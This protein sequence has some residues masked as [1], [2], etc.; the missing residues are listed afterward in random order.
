MLDSV[1]DPPHAPPV[2]TGTIDRNEE[3]AAA[4]APRWHTRLDPRR[5]LAAAIGWAI[6]GVIVVASLVAANLAATAAER[7]GRADTQRLLEQFAAQLHHALMTNIETRLTI[8]RATAA[9]IA[10]SGDRGKAAL[11][12]H[13]EAV[14]A[15][16]PE[17]AWIGVTDADGRVVAATQGV[18]EA[19]SVADRPWFQTARAGPFVGE[20]RLH[21]RLETLLAR[22]ADAGPQ[23]YV[24]AAA[25]I[26]DARGP[27]AG[28]IGGYLAWS[29]VERLQR[30]LLG[31][32][33]SGVPL[34]LV[35]LGGDGR[36]IGGP[37]GWVGR[38]FA[39]L[40]ASAGGRYLVARHDP[41]LR[42]DG[43]ALPW[44]VVVRQPVALALAPAQRAAQ[45]VFLAVL[46]AGLLAALAA[47]LLTQVLTRRLGVLAG[48]I[49]SVRRGERSA[50]VV[51]AGRD[52]VG[53]I[54]IVLAALVD[55]LQREKGA[56]AQLNR[57]LDQRVAE[58][59]ARIERLAEEGRAAA[60][61]RERLRLA[62]ELHDTLAHSLMALLAQI[63]L[64]RKL[65]RRLGEDELDA[66]LDRAEEVAARGLTE[67]RA[68][69]TQMRDGG[70]QEV[71]LGA[72]L[73]ELLARFTQ[74]SG[75]AAELHADV[76]AAAMS[77]ERAQTLYRIAEEALRNVE[78]HAGA[79]RVTVELRE[80]GEPIAPR[81]LLR[82]AD[83]GAGFDPAAPVP[84]HYGLR[85]MREQAALIEAA[86]S[87]HSAPGAG[88]RIELEFAA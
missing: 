3:T 39:Q 18:F 83:D 78:R 9:Q 23:R 31:A 21:R 64:V 60:V 7:R 35:M 88:T 85:G 8:M 34:E 4:R 27:A 55:Q 37:A 57:E 1:A 12:R 68:A 40:D 67:A 80:S 73:R 79:R 76:A 66:E 58:R 45:S 53:Q 6:F 62:R 86:L 56:L 15:Q 87:V 5:H 61:T 71:G 50:L 74:R 44:S 52:E 47:V 30:E 16:F 26:G 75:I 81:R 10:A 14:Q 43:I 49:G 32:L 17:F 22:T 70:V 11:R 41:H 46:G 29:W 38:P 13:L 84:G 36:V 54:G 28:V 19:Q 65:H 20:V 48:A 77:D 63:R 24:D 2:P 42:A 69:I 59:S 82:I 72:A 25:P 51:P 33:D